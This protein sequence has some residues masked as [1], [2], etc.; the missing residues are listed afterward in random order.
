MILTARDR[1]FGQTR[2]PWTSLNVQ[3][4]VEE[5]TLNGY[6]VEVYDFHE[7][8]NGNI[9]ME[10]KTI[11]YAF[12]QKE[13]YRQYIKDLMFH[14]NKTNEIIP[15]YD[16]LMCHENKGYQEIYNKEIDLKSLWG[17]YYTSSEELD[18]QSFNYPVVLKTTSGNNGKGVFLIRDA[19]HMENVT[20][21]LRKRIGW[22]KHLDL[23]RRK[24]IR[25]KTFPEYPGFSNE[26]D[27]IEYKEYIKVEQNFVIQEFVP[28]LSYDHRVLI[29]FDRYYVMKRKIKDGD[30]RASGSKK[31]VF[32]AVPDKELL[33]YSRSVYE[34]FD[35]PFLSI[36]VLFDGKN[37]FL[38]EYQ[39][40]HFGMAVQ[41]KS[42]GFFVRNDAGE[43]SYKKEKPNQEKVFAETLT[44]YL[45]EKYF[46]DK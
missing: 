36:D 25:N 35:S 29:A 27:Y 43:W 31:F 21:R 33:E 32:N 1:F 30:F 10:N 19:D 22:G 4:I 45:N 24:H 28:D 16:L 15:S 18:V 41:A 39:A 12:S 9:Q 3:K 37:Y 38:A 23:L 6:H 46:S 40:L 17:L 26:Q 44:S 2:K 34:K 7:V 11:L 13:N 14:L 5:L 20:Q 42:K 8:V